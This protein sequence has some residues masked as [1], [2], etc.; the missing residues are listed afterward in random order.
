[1]SLAL[2]SE[3]RQLPRSY[4]VYLVAYTVSM[5][6]TGMQFIANSWL[7]MQLTNRGGAVSL[8][9]AAGAIPGILFSTAIGTYV[10]RYDR[11][12]LA[13]AADIFRGVVLIGVVY[14]Y[15]A[16]LLTAPQVYLMS[17][18]VAFGDEVYTLA[19]TVLVREI[20]SKDLLLR[21]NSTISMMSQG[22]ILVGTAL[23]GLIVARSSP[24]TVI[25][26]NAASFFFSSLCIWAIRVDH[27][28]QPNG[29]VQ[30]GRRRLS[31]VLDEICAAWRYIRSLRDVIFCYAMMTVIRA[32]LFFINV[33]LPPFSKNVLRV[34]AQGFGYI[35]AG[36][37]VGAVLGNFA[38]PRAS[39]RFGHRA[40]LVAGPLAAAGS[41]F[42]FSAAHGL[43]T[44]IGAYVFLGIACQAG[45]LYMTV[46]QTLVDIQYQ[47]RVHATFNVVFA[48]SSLV[49]YLL[50]GYSADIVPIRGLYATQAA[51]LGVSGLFAAGWLFSRHTLLLRS[52]E[53]A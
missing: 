24:L 42:A 40:L 29:I 10:D 22:G 21:A 16:G 19:A 46:S 41:L 51:L 33:L 31:Q 3:S 44:A 48:A 2:Q 15:R 28:L 26:I 39:A 30:A 18:L 17:F 1:M 9:L 8:V 34:G 38:L 45:V 35:D 49:V 36:F 20:V 27:E 23:G 43:V 11:K 13:V 47:G 12:K 52:E 53:A 37:A 6:G 5:L 50:A 32:T 7:V 14:L 4:F 25:V